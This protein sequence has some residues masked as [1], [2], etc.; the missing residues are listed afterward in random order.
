M[1][2]NRRLVMAFLPYIIVF[3]FSKTHNERSYFQSFVL[4][5]IYRNASNTHPGAYFICKL[6]AG[7]YSKVVAYSRGHVYNCFPFTITVIILQI[8]YR[9]KT[10]QF[11]YIL[12]FIRTLYSSNTNQEQLNYSY[13]TFTCPSYSTYFFL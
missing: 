4:C 3:V 5:N 1:L 11:S 13:L 7:A 9:S 8:I 6:G 10:E 2:I 12:L